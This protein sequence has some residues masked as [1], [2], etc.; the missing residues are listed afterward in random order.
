MFWIHSHPHNAYSQT[1]GYTSKSSERRAEMKEVI[2][3]R[4]K[5]GIMPQ[6]LFE[7][8]QSSSESFGYGEILNNVRE[9]REKYIYIHSW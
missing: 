6:M 4:Q 3:T 5:V 2:N 8:A 9:N 7:M 1:E